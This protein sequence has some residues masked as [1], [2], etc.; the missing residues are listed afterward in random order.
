MKRADLTIDR[1]VCFDVPFARL[2]EVARATGA[3]SVEA[4]QRHVAF[5]QKCRLCHPYVRRMLRTGETA[6]HHVL[7]DAD[8]P[9]GDAPG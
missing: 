9:G 1:C 7:T 6:F 4:L 8:E 3:G 2:A 5:G